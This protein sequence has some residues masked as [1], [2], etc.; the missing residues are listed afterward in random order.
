MRNLM[1]AV[2]LLLILGL[3]AAPLAAQDT[4]EGKAAQAPGPDRDP[5]SI[6]QEIMEELEFPDERELEEGEEP[7]EEEAEDEEAAGEEP[8]E[9]PEDEGTEPPAW[10]RLPH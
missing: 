10:P 7:P 8:E 6:V 3:T 9:G 5:E 1:A 4:T 2:V